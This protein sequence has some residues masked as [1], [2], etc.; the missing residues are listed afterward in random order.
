MKCMHIII[1][2]MMTYQIFVVLQRQRLAESPW[3]WAQLHYLL[4][5]AV[6]MVLLCFQ[7]LAGSSSV[8]K[9]YRGNGSYYYC[10]THLCIP[11]QQI[12]HC[13]T[14]MHEGACMSHTNSSM[15]LIRVSLNP[16]VTP[17][18]LSVLSSR[19]RR[20]KPLILLSIIIHIIHSDTIT[21]NDIVFL[22]FNLLISC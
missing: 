22:P 11:G 10:Y 20:A 6:M 8:H 16:Y 15:I 3:C 13:I 1:I 14:I 5:T 12:T 7:E 21:S 2:I 9:A 4:K 17:N 19:L 18:C